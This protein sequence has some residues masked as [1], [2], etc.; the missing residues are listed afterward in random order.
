MHISFRSVCARSQNFYGRTPAAQ[1]EGAGVTSSKKSFAALRRRKTGA[2][3]PQKQKTASLRSAAKGRMQNPFGV[4]PLSGFR[5]RVVPPAA[6]RIAAQNAPRGQKAA[7]EAAVAADRFH[8]VFAARRGKAAMMPEARADMAFI[9]L[10]GGDHKPPHCGAKPRSVWHRSFR[11][12]GRGTGAF[13]LVGRPR[14]AGR[15]VCGRFSFCRSGSLRRRLRQG[16]C[17]RFIRQARL[18]QQTRHGRA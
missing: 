13:Y 3:L 15:G 12:Y 11:R 8:R 4:C 14:G 1:K 10:D 6:E 17:P 5:H 7:L 18:R 2:G 16:A 9:K